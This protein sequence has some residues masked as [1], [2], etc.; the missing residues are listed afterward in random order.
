MATGADRRYL[1]KHGRQW[2]VVLAVPRD[3]RNVF[4]S[5]QLKRS[6]KTDSLKQAQ[7]LRWPIVAQ[8]QNEIDSARQRRGAEVR[9]R[10]S[11]PITADA[12]E[13]RDVLKTD[14]QWIRKG[15]DRFLADAHREMITQAADTIGVTNGHAL[16]TDFRGIALGTATP[17]MLHRDQWL[18]E[19]DV[20]PRTRLER[21]KS[22]SLL[23]TW[24]AEHG[25]RTVES[26]TRREAGE[27]L[28]AV[29]IA[30]G[31]APQTMQKRLSDLALYWD[32]LRERGHLGLDGRD[33]AN[34][35]RGHKTITR[36]ARKESPQKPK[37]PF[38]TD[39][40]RLLLHDSDDAADITLRDYMMIAALSGMRISEIAALT[41]GDCEGGVFNIRSGKTPAAVRKVPIHSALKRII[42]RRTK[43]RDP[44]DWLLVDH[45]EKTPS[46]KPRADTWD[47]SRPISKRFTYFRKRVGV[48]DQAAGKRYAAADFHS[49]RRT[50]ITLAGQAGISF[51]VIQQVVGHAREGV[52]QNYFGGHTLEKLRACVE[53]V[54]LPPRKR[55]TRSR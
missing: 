45:L 33:R 36:A 1:Q 28:T 15:E 18:A 5:A 8:M 30:A 26:I 37:R 21:K 27:F 39:E 3:L 48:H 4:G 29:L 16:A 19:I 49:F 53:A 42:A 41:V 35:W 54:K 46:V 9:L 11:D 52:T 13:W 22:L 40:L 44:N 24:A 34:P 7:R 6:L 55:P 12:L 38:T 51:E 47:R 32:W 23:E 10:A 25:H 43:G 50:F 14:E 17:L 20:T 2:R 31:K